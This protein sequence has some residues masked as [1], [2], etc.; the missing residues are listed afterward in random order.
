MTLPY[1]HFQY[2]DCTQ[3]RFENG[4]W[5]APVIEEIVTLGSIISADLLFEVH[6]G[7]PP[8]R[9]G[10][11]CRFMGKLEK[12]PREAKFK[13]EKD[14]ITAAN[15]TAVK[16]WKELGVSGP[17]PIGYKKIPWE[18]IQGQILEANRNRRRIKLKH[19]YLP[20]NAQVKKAKKIKPTAPP[21]APKPSVGATKGYPKIFAETGHPS[22]DLH[23]VPY[24][25]ER[26]IRANRV[27]KHYKVILDGTVFVECCHCSRRLYHHEFTVEHLKPRALGGGDNIEN[28]RP[29]CWKCNQIRPCEDISHK[30]S[31]NPTAG[32]EK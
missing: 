17:H 24:I 4:A 10:I 28:L 30:F 6:H 29:S 8:T 32:K 1:C 18:I 26:G 25:R 11:A 20:T 3:N 7:Y 12:D 13:E 2:L 5:T 14:G 9:F 19:G 31:P 22:D 16:T 27:W 21:P 23:I 15:S